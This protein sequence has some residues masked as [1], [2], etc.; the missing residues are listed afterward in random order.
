MVPHKKLHVCPL[1]L[2]KPRHP[3]C[4]LP[5]HLFGVWI[6]DLRPSASDLSP[7]TFGDDVRWDR[8]ARVRASQLNLWHNLSSWALPHVFRDTSICL[9]F[10]MNTITLSSYPS[11]LLQNCLRLI[12]LD[13]TTVCRHL[14][15]FLLWKYR[16]TSNRRSCF[17]L[18]DHNSPE[19]N[20]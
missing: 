7:R 5:V 8:E 14:M 2:Q 20:I 1:T 11:Y 17:L 19:K 3:A 9:K 15:M 12:W 10:Q 6:P 16:W 13:P 18:G 4:T